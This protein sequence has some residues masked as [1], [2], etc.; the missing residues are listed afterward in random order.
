MV[1]RGFH[2]VGIAGGFIEVEADPVLLVDADGLLALPV[3]AELV[4]P[5]P[6]RLRELLDAL[7]PVQ[8]CQL[9]LHPPPGPLRNCPRPTALEEPL[10]L[11]V[12][13]AP[14]H[15]QVMSCV[16]RH[17]KDLVNLR[18]I[19]GVARACAARL[20]FDLPLHGVY[21]LLRFGDDAVELAGRVGVGTDDHRLAIDV[22][23]HDQ[24]AL[25]ARRE[26]QDSAIFRALNCRRVASLA[27]S[28]R[29]R[30]IS[31]SK[32]GSRPSETTLRC[33]LPLHGVQHLLGLREESFE[34]GGDAHGYDHR[35]TFDVLHYDQA[36]R[37]VRPER[38][39]VLVREGE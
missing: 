24:A 38:Y 34:V 4:Q 31:E 20:G 14:D 9:H 25:S 8:L 13:E 26:K 1:V 29:H 36:V 18:P 23:E 6:R 32:L 28:S 17:L 22:F 35:F 10:G 30:G 21:N 37:V 7:H 27:R 19:T 2:V 33:A 3:S 12:P 15:T 39:S 16:A 11:F 5:V